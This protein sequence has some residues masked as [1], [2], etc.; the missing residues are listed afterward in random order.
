MQPGYQ[1]TKGDK[2]G[3]TKAVDFWALGVTCYMLICGQKPHTPERL[4]EY[5]EST[6]MLLDSNEVFNTGRC[7]S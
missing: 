6:G 4:D 5:Q 3:Y 1:Q 7:D 2:K